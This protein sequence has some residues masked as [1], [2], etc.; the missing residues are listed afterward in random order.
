[1]SRRFGRLSHLK[2]QSCHQH[3]RASNETVLEV[4][5][6]YTRTRMT[7][8][9]AVTNGAAAARGDAVNSRARRVV[10]EYERHA[11][12]IHE[13]SRVRT[14]AKTDLFFA[15]C[16]KS[17]LRASSSAPLARRRT[18]RTSYSASSSPQR[19]PPSA[20]AA[21]WRRAPSAPLGARRTAPRVRGCFFARENARL[22]LARLALATGAG[23]CTHAA[24]GLNRAQPWRNNRV[25]TEVWQVQR[26]I[27]G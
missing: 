15:G 5:R 20:G 7:I 27:T 16:A 10:G 11:R 9:R 23:H 12:R 6:P 19:A 8:A 25:V 24:R 22:K 26:C 14:W 3:E 1:M 2:R 18:T 13:H 17:A 21:P 4:T